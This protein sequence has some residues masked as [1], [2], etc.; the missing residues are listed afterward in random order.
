[1]GRSES[2][3]QLV[4][5]CQRTKDGVWLSELLDAKCKGRRECVQDDPVK[6]RSS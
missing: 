3:S 6:L 5:R 1:M 4:V 2:R